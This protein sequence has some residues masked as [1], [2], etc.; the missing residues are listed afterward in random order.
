MSEQKKSSSDLTWHWVITG[1]MLSMVI[2]YNVTSHFAGSTIQINITEE[3]RIF[4]RTVFYGISIILF[5]IANLLR[6][7]LLRLNQTIPG[8]STAKSR[9]L[10]TIIMT[11]SLIGIV[12][13]CGFVMF[14]LGDGYNTLYIFSL[15]GT[16]GIYLHKP[17]QEEYQ[18][19]IDALRIQ[20]L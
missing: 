11:M 9:Y 12:S 4:I 17:K 16:L 2:A 3:Q 15:L 13:I 14:I 6:H 1:I 20:K 7:I 19:I 8:D 5:P 10:I 18:Q